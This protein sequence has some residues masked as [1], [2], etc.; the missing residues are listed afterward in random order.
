MKSR[1]RPGMISEMTKGKTE[2]LLTITGEETYA[3]GH[4]DRS[5]TRSRAVCEMGSNS[6]SESGGISGNS[7]AGDKS[8]ACV[9]SCGTSVF[10]YREEDPSG[11]ATESVMAF[12]GGCC[13][14]TRTGAISTQM[15]FIPDQETRC[16]YDTP[17]GSIPMTIYT[18]LVAS[19]V[20]GNNFHAR[21]R[22]RL[23]LEGAEPAECAVTVQAK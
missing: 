23:T 14:I 3:D 4:K 15:R 8:G 21:I 22:Y 5:R 17:F 16:V 6:C 18:H 9:K 2:V 19:R 12:S 10:R 20:V 1:A 7:D 13:S 11:G